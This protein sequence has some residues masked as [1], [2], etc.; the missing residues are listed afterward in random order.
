MKRRSASSNYNSVNSKIGTSTIP[1]AL[2]QTITGALANIPFPFGIDSSGNYGYKKAGA[3]TVVPFSSG[4]KYFCAVG[5]SYSSDSSATYYENGILHAS[6]RTSISQSL[7]SYVTMTWVG[8]ANYVVKLTAAK[9]FTC[10][11]TYYGRSQTEVNT[12][13]TFAAGQFIV[14]FDYRSAPAVI[15]V[16]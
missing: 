16:K 6:I 7:G 10:T 5:A 4:L 13:V 12:E 9:A 15:L 3:D 14:D 2:G 11:Y 8:G 1:S